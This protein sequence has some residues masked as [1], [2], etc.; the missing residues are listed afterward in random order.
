LPRERTPILTSGS[1]QAALAIPMGSSSF[2]RKSADALLRIFVELEAKAAL[3]RHDP[4]FIGSLHRRICELQN[5]GSHS[6]EQ[7]QRE[8]EEKVTSLRTRKAEAK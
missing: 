1:I 6:C 3:H 2:I 8:S 7:K 4:V 5:D